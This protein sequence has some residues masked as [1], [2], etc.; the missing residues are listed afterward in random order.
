MG[1]HKERVKLVVTNVI[2]QEHVVH[3]VVAIQ[4]SVMQVLVNVRQLPHVDRRQCLT[5]SAQALY[6]NV[7][8]RLFALQELR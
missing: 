5:I 8:Q 2:Q 1:R 7:D 4:I 6:V 3:R